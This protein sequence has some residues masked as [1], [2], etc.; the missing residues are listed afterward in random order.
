MNQ[1]TTVRLAHQLMY[2][3]S[4][5]MYIHCGDSVSVKREV[6]IDSRRICA[7]KQIVSFRHLLLKDKYKIIKVEMSDT[8]IVIAGMII[9]LTLPKNT[10]ITIITNIVAIRSVL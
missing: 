3:W 2:D 8:G 1:F 4:L 7:L 10:K 9:A 5:E 6:F